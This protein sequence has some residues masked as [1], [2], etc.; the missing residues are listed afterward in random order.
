MNHI[1]HY[2]GALPHQIHPNHCPPLQNFPARFP[3]PT[4]PDNVNALMISQMANDGTLQYHN[5]NVQHFIVENRHMG[6]NTEPIKEPAQPT[7]KPERISTGFQTIETDANFK[8]SISSNTSQRLTH[9]CNRGAKNCAQCFKGQT[10][11]MVDVSTMTDND[12]MD[13]AASWASVTTQPG[14][15]KVA[16]YLTSLR[17]FLKLSS[18]PEGKRRLGDVRI[19]SSSDGTRLYCCPECHMAYPDKS[20]LEPHL[21]AH[22]IERRFICTVCGAGLKRKE[23][24]DR[25]ALSHSD[26]RPYSCQLCPKTFKR[27][28][29]L[30]RHAIVHT[31][32]KG[33][34]CS[35]CGKA[36]YRR[37]HLRKHCQGHLAKRLRAAAQS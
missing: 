21:A 3:S 27:N 2:R 16:E 30:A 29:H 37:D 24:L 31:G 33:Q 14:N 15:T 9:H 22:K 28:E 19:I 6:Q 11:I 35:E 26:E 5:T 25:H 7:R 1:S 36:F 4:I 20:L 13:Q 18:P 12:E 10:K 17:Q 34:V 32:H 23:H 8:P